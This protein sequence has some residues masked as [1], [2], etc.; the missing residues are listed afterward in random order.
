MFQSIV[1]LSSQ[2]HRNLKLRPATGYDYARGQSRVL[3]GLAE[4]A[5]AAAFYPIVFLDSR[6]RGPVPHALL[7]LGDA[8]N[9]FVDT[10]GRWLCPLVPAAIARYPFVLARSSPEAYALSFDEKSARISSQDGEALFDAEGQLSPL[11][12]RILDE[13][14]KLAQQ[15]NQ[16]AAFG[17][18]LD[19]RG[20]LR[21]VQIN[22]SIGG[23]EKLSLGGMKLVDEKVFQLL[24]DD[25]VLAWWRNGYLALI[26]AHLLSIAHLQ[27]LAQRKF[28]TASLARVD[29]EPV[30][31][32]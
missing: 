12:R 10:A 1:G 9:L 14:T 4:L 27:M 8:E 15:L 18:A 6:D 32:G 7:G 21:E 2:Q 20:L 31:L 29:A 11:T 17:A 24:P 19:G 23:G 26:H 28:A 13:Q 22:L 5:R 3:I 25:V 16:A 30:V